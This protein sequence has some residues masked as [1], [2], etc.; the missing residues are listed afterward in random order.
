[1]TGGKERKREKEREDLDPDIPGLLLTQD[2][3]HNLSPYLSVLE[4]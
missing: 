4:H 3:T 2:W 1:M